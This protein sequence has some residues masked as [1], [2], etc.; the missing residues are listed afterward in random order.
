[1]NVDIER[2]VVQHLLADPDLTDVIGENRVS[3]ELPPNAEL[4]RVRIT[5]N[6]GTIPARGWLYRY[7]ITVEGW[8]DDKRSAWEALVEALASLEGGLDG[9]LVDGGVIT[10]VDQDSGVAWVPDPETDTPRYLATVQIT[11]HPET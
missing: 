1:M 3:T 5:L 9:A 7:R 10:A 4:P 2:I 11:A 8:G 6:G